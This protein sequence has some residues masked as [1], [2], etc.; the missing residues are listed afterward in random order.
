MILSVYTIFDRMAEESGPVFTAK[1]D[2]VAY[3]SFQLMLRK[4]QSSGSDLTLYCVGSYDNEDLTLVAGKKYV[5]TYNPG[6]D[7]TR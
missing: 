1:N 6:E 7:E 3:R 5:V 4:E 2:A